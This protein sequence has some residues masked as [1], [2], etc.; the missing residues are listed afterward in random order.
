M[1]VCRNAEGVPGQKE[2]GVP[3]ARSSNTWREKFHKK[4][5]TTSSN[6]L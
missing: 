4:K 6:S 1:L 5:S 2:V 3:C